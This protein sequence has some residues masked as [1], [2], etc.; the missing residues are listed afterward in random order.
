MKDS[1]PCTACRYCCE[2]CPAGLDIPALIA[3]YNDLKVQVSFNPIMRLEILPEEKRPHACLQ[4]GACTQ[5]C[6]QG[7]AIP[8]VMADLAAIYDRAPKWSE[9]CEKRNRNN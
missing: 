4:C 7:I 1:V 2:G 5:I 9:I 3:E 6:P 8:D